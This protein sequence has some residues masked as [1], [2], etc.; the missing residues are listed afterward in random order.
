MVIVA[1][2]RSSYE[3]GAASTLVITPTC[4]LGGCFWSAEFMPDIMQKISYI[5]P[6]RWALDAVKTLQKGAAFNDIALNLVYCW[7]LRLSF[8]HCCIQVQHN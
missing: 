8:C 6:Q 2:A 5:I 1:F 7:R 3:A 4:M